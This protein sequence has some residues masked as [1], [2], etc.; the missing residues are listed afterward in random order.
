MNFAVL[1]PL[2]IFMGWYYTKHYLTEFTQV[3]K[4]SKIDTHYKA[5]STLYGRLQ[6]RD[7]NIRLRLWLR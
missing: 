6:Q 5:S 4:E 2:N 3:C 1:V 7:S